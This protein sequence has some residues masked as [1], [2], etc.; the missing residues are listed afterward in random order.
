MGW[1]SSPSLSPCLPFFG[2]IAKG[3]FL[4]F[5]NPHGDCL[6][7][8]EHSNHIPFADR[9]LPKVEFL[10]KGM[11]QLR[12]TENKI[13]LTENIFHGVQT[14]VYHVQV[15]SCNDKKQFLRSHVFTT[16]GWKLPAL[17]YFI[18]IFLKGLLLGVAPI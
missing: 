5:S 16:G 6:I 17:I 12:G 3:A 9:G 18:V 7:L 1:S 14:V 11:S 13:R 2:K 4:T 15:F 10:T 8:V